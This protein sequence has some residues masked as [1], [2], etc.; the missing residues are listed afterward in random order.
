MNITSLSWVI[1]LGLSLGLLGCSSPLS[2]APAEPLG[3]QI[4]MTDVTSPPS[5]TPD[6][7]SESNS[8]AQQLPITATITIKGSVINLEV[9]RTPL[10]QAIGLM[11]RPSISD[12]HGM[13]FPFSPPRPVNFWM[14]NV[15]INLDMLFIRDGRVLAIEAQVPPCRTEICPQYGPAGVPVDYVLELGGGRAAELGVQI[16]DPIILSDLPS[17]L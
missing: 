3:H 4:S 15:E 13:L 6:T 17:P 9:A 10:Q 16:G 11:Y 7:A 5:S 1:S 2:V 12:D 8:L 14:K